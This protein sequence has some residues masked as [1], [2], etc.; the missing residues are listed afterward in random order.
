[1]ITNL[2]ERKTILLAQVEKLKREIDV[3]KLP[4]HKELALCHHTGSVRY[5]SLDRL[6]DSSGNYVA[7]ED[8]TLAP[9]CSILM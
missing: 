2:E 8:C 1:M 4:E 3:L 6:Q 9:R 7:G 5:L